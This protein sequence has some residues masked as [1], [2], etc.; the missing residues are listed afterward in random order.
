LTCHNVTGQVDYVLQVVARDLDDYGRLTTI[1][2]NLP[3]VT[4]IHSSLSLRE[5]KGFSGLPVT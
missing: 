3:G 5:V 1:L 4:A 2:R